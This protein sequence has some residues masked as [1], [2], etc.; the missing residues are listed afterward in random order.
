MAEGQA[1]IPATGT[2]GKSGLGRR[3]IVELLIGAAV[4]MLLVGIVGPGIVAWWYQPPIADAFS[5]ASSVRAAL[6]QFVWLQL[7]AAVGLA[8]ASTL[9]SFLVRRRLGKKPSP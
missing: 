5:C 8:L 6:E 3:L 9:I 2:P 7:S 4:G 1:G